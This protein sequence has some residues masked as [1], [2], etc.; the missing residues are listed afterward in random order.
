MQ[1]TLCGI[2]WEREVK[3][4]LCSLKC[5]GMSESQ[6]EAK[7]INTEQVKIEWENEKTKFSLV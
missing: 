5:T 6:L 3:R 4:K 2:C 1:V 7:L